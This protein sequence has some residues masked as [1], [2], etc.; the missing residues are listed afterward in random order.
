MSALTMP[1][2]LHSLHITLNLRRRSRLKAALTFILTFSN[3]LLTVVAASKFGKYPLL[4]FAFFRNFPP[5]IIYSWKITNLDKEAFGP[6]IL[7]FFVPAIQSFVKDLFIC[8]CGKMPSYLINYYCCFSWLTLICAGISNFLIPRQEDKGV[9]SN[10][11]SS[12]LST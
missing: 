10:G 6:T 9:S 5:Y 12:D 2:L 8:N 7:N 1:K 3:S 4:P 11:F